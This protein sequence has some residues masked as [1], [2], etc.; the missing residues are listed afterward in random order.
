MATPRHDTLTPDGKPLPL[1]TPATAAGRS[2]ARFNRD[3]LAGHQRVVRSQ[4]V[5]GSG[6]TQDGA[7]QRRSVEIDEGAAASH[8]SQVL[9]QSGLE[10]RDSD[11]A[12]DYITVTTGHE[13]PARPCWRN[14]KPIG[15]GTASRITSRNRARVRGIVW[16]RE[17][18]WSGNRKQRAAISSPLADRRLRRRPLRRV[19]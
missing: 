9:A 18:A 16:G 15:R 4:V 3:E 17:C 6:L 19:E 10:V 2:C 13:R 8:R 12:H 11:V 1:L 14:P 7:Q 5:E